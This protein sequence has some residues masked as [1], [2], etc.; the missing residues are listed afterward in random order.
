MRIVLVS[1]GTLGDVHPFVAVA[2]ELAAAGL[3]PVLAAAES[4]RAIADRHGI[5][6]HPVRPDGAELLADMGLD[7]A[8]VARA[9]ASDLGFVIDRVILPYADRTLADLGAAMAGADLALCGSF[10]VLGRIAAEAAGVPVMSLLLQPMALFSADDPPVTPTGS[11]LLPA[12]RRA[13]GARAVRPLLRLARLANRR[14]LRPFASLRASLDL[15]PARGDELIDGPLSAERVF[16]LWSPELAPLPRDAAPTVTMAGCTFYDGGFAG[17]SPPPALDRFLSDGPPPMV[18]TL[19]SLAIH[20]EGGFY[21]ASAAAARAAGMRAVLLVGDDLV[22]DHRHLASDDVL[23]AGYAPHSAVF[24]RAA[25]VAHH[26]GAGTIAQAMRAGVPQLV[27]PVFGDQFDNAA[28]LARRG[29]AICLPHARYTAE[30]AGRSL[31]RLL[32]DR[33]IAD[34]AGEIAGRVRR[35]NG[36]AVVACAIAR[37]GDPSRA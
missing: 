5:A 28:R 12:L 32:G 7:E 13:L 8:T 6:F 20:A 21:A 2:I 11:A 33:A 16:A 29:V 17:A 4:C 26:G 34:R 10:S 25:A 15:P 31:T 14:R 3:T 27:C 19:G 9:V 24:A 37:R 18:F 1:V 22:A 30:S 35:E 36:A 23:V